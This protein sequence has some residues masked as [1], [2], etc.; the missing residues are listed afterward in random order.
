MEEDKRELKIFGELVTPIRFDLFTEWYLDLFLFTVSIREEIEYKG[1]NNIDK[2]GYKK[3]ADGL[4]NFSEK[5][6][7]FV[8]DSAEDVVLQMEQF[9]KPKLQILSKWIG[10]KEEL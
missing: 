4:I 8:G 7:H 6:K 3:T 1:T 2:A 10:R 9:V 5:R